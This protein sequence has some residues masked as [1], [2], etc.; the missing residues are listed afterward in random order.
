MAKSEASNY[1]APIYKDRAL[2]YLLKI[3]GGKKAVKLMNDEQKLAM[4]VARD[5]IAYEMMFNQ[6]KWFR[7][8]EYQKNSLLLAKPIPV[9]E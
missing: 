4:K 2:K 7:P 8:F 3:A 9:G 5:K 6:L 1:V